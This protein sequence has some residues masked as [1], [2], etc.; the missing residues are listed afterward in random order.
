MILSVPSGA[1]PR[2]HEML[3]VQRGKCEALERLLA[4]YRSRSLTREEM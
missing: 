2:Y 4:I 3:R 1:T